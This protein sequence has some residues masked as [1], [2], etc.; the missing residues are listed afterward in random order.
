MSKIPGKF[1]TICRMSHWDVI[2]RPSMRPPSRKCFLTKRVILVMS[3][4]AFLP[5]TE[6][7]IVADWPVTRILPYRRG[8]SIR[9]KVSPRQE[10]AK[11][12]P[13]STFIAGAA[14]KGPGAA[15][16]IAT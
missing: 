12:S 11:T 4:R 6:H 13:L 5:L 9:A 3:P 10:V 8:R 16:A 14:P 1:E 15:G 2:L 7:R